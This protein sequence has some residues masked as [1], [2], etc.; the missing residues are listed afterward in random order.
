M[1]Q[2]YSLWIRA[3]LGIAVIVICSYSNLSFADDLYKAKLANGSVLYTSKKDAPNAQ[4]AVLPSISRE[5]A[6]QIPNTATDTTAKSSKPDTS[7][8]THGGVRCED[9]PDSDGSVICGDGFRDSLIRFN[10]ACRGTKLSVVRAVVMGPGAIK[11]VVR[12]ERAIQADGVQ[13]M[14]K[15]RGEFGDPDK[16]ILATGPTEV[17][18]SQAGE[19]LANYLKLQQNSGEYPV[20]NIEVSCGNCG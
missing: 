4:I 7:C 9:G 6:K 5:P 14:V 15:I 16:L 8:L 17:K 2:N 1:D 18:P 19:Y 20:D 13:V 10:F 12:N 3:Y 11:I